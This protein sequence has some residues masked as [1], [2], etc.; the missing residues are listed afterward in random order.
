MWDM[1]RL[2]LIQHDTQRLGVCVGTLIACDC[3]CRE[4]GAAVMLSSARPAAAGRV[5]PT[6][7]A[8]VG[9]AVLQ[10]PLQNLWK[11]GSP[12]Q[13]G[14]PGGPR[15]GMAAPTAVHWGYQGTPWCPV[16]RH[17]DRARG[18][19]GPLHW[20]PAGEPKLQGGPPA[21]RGRQEGAPR[22]WFA[23]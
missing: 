20:P 17:R 12:I 9:A 10:S 21:Q 19:G 13:Q 1:S 22:D 15:G 5:P 2:C 8:A 16:W 3:K 7:A 23:V 11:C 14:T 4:R 18:S 6:G